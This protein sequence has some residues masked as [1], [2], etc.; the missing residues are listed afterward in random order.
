MTLDPRMPLA[1]LAALSLACSAASA[2]RAEAPALG[3]YT[4]A[5]DAAHL[6]AH[7]GQIV[8]EAWLEIEAS[9]DT[10]PYP[11]R[12]TLQF[13]V[14]GQAKSTFST[15]GACKADG[16]GLL[17]NASLSAEEKDLCKRQ[18]D[19][20][21]NCRID[22]EHSGSFRIAATPD[23]VLVTLAER[24]EMPGRDNYLYLSP[25]NVENHAFAL[26]PA[27]ASACK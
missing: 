8:K 26:K 15:F 13:S 23:G 22:Y 24:L 19:G 17:C 6:A 1:A 20:V 9:K 18:G 12:A 3:C 16:G 5:Y 11:F 27:P 21:R 7:K 4:R 2:A 10:P 14:K 25:S